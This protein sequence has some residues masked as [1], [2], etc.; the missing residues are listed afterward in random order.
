MF[1][2]QSSHDNTTSVCASKKYN[3]ISHRLYLTTVS[4]TEICFPS[5]IE[6]WTGSR[7]FSGKRRWN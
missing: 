7:V 5:F 2:E 3:K 6:Y 1:C 4:N